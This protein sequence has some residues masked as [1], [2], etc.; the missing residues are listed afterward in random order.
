MFFLK[1]P[2]SLFDIIFGLFEGQY[3][4]LHTAG[5]DALYHLRVNT[6]SVRELHLIQDRQT[7]PR[8]AAHIEHPSAIAKLMF[9]STDQSFQ[10]RQRLFYSERD[11][12]VLLVDV[13][14]YFGHRFLLQMVIQ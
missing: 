8:P 4:I 5:Q 7:A 3:Q 9:D 10:V 13:M 14:K 12:L 6:V 11:F 2:P 1:G